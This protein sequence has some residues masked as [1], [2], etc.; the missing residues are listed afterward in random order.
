MNLRTVPLLL[1]F[2]CALCLRC[3]AEPVLAA[4]QPASSIP[5]AALMTPADFA[6]RLSDGAVPKALILQVGFRTL[7]DQAHIPGARFA[8]PA[9]QESG[10]NLLRARVAKLRHEAPILIYCGCCPWSHCPNIAAAY[11]ALQTLGFTHVTVLHI[12][13]N[14]GD[15]WVNA[16]Y[17]VTRGAAV[18]HAHGS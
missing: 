10:L 7:F 6:A 15:D 5:A 18:Q 2:A 12:P 17:P 3:L 16:G 1:A 9:S 8:G 14:F 4:T 11:N 13:D